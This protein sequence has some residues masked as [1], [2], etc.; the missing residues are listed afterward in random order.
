MNLQLPSPVTDLKKPFGS[1]GPG[2]LVKRDDL[3]HPVISGNKWR[4]LKYNLEAARKVGQTNI[5]SYGGV[6]SNHLHALAY[7]GKEFGFK[8]IAIVRGEDDPGNPT[9]MDLRAAGM[10]LIFIS[11]EDYRQKKE[12]DFHKRYI[13]EDVFVIPEGGANELGI[14]GFFDLSLETGT[15]FTD[16]FVPVGSGTTL[17]GLIRAFPQ[18]RIHG[19]MAVRDAALVKYFKDLNNP[20]L[21]IH[22][23]F[24]FGGFAKVDNDLLKFKEDFEKE[25]EIKTDLVYTSKMFFAIFAL[26]GTGLFKAEDRILAIHTGGL[27]GNRGFNTN[28]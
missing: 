16:I 19:I 22:E 8:T 23:N 11:R 1:E 13:S 15:D 24:T 26:A 9:L 21:Y 6:F 5:L 17:S 25:F 18:S 4:K 27:Q 2:L 28:A 20:N 3:I 7:A 14:Q 12:K 10:K